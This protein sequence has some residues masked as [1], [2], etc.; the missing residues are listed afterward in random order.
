MYSRYLKRPAFH[1]FVFPKTVI[2]SFQIAFPASIVRSFLSP[3]LWRPAA[4]RP[5]WP[6]HPSR[7]PMGLPWRPVCLEAVWAH[8]CRQTALTVFL[9]YP[10]DGSQ[11]LRNP[12]CRPKHPVLQQSCPVG[13]GL[14][15]PV[16]ANLAV[17]CSVRRSAVQSNQC[18]DANFAAARRRIAV[19]W[20]RQTAL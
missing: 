6:E 5:T 17:Y 7:L 8:F 10:V 4:R 2:S 12:L 15:P 1:S 9:Q 16:C 11:D 14:F 20:I 3:S 18:F 19:V 13:R